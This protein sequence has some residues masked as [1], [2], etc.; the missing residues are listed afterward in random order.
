MS[1]HSI[2]YYN[3]VCYL[4]ATCMLLINFYTFFSFLK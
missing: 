1:Y 4:Y 2:F 3:F